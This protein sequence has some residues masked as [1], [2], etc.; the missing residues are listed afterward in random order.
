MPKRNRTKEQRALHSPV[1]ARPNAASASAV[2]SAS[3]PAKTAD[4]EQARAAKLFADSIKAHAA[5]D[6]AEADRKAAK[7]AEAR[8]HDELIA[9]KDRA[10]EVIRGLRAD[11]RPRQKMADAEA[12]YRAALAELNEF[13]TGERPHWAP[14][15]APAEQAGGVDEVADDGATTDAE[16][17]ADGSSHGSSDDQPV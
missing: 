9:A 15:P 16:S 6:R 8:K 4:T 11:G 3:G 17:D 14:A 10:A 12:A 7:A 1:A 13:E 5:A 2:P